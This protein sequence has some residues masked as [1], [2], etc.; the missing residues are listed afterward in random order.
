MGVPKFFRYVSERYPCLNE[1]VRENQIP[2][3]DNLYLDMNGIIH[4]CSH[5]DDGNVH[6]RMTEEQMFKA[7]FHYIDVLFRIIQPQ[8]LMF[9]AIDG[10][11]PRAKMNQQR[12]RRFRTAKE[13]EM[14]EAKAREKGEILPETAR[15]DSNC[16]TP[17][18][19][20]M[21]RLQ[22]ALKFYVK[23]RISQQGAWQK[24]KVILSGHETPGE[25]EHKIMEYIRFLKSKPDW[26][27]NTRHCL[28]GLDADLIMLGL[29]THEQHFSL[30]R[31][32]V[33]FGRQAK[34]TT[35]VDT[36]RF[37]L[38]HL[39][40]LRE[41]IEM[42]FQVL[43]TTLSFPFDIESIVDDWV[44]MGF[45]VGNDF[46]PHLPNLHIN[47]NA[48]PD[49]YETYKRV[50]PTLDGYINDSGRINLARLEVLL[51]KLGEKDKE[52]FEAHYDDLRYLESKGIRTAF[53]SDSEESDPAASFDGMSDDLARLAKATEEM[54]TSTSD[55]EEENEEVRFEKDF[56]K[57]KRNYY[58]TKLNYPKVDESVLREQTEC[59]IEALQWTLYYYYRGIVSWGWFYPHHY[60]PFVS[61]LKDFSRFNIKFDMGKPFLPFEQLLAV[62]PSASRAHLPSAYQ[63]LMTD[64]QSDIIEYY[65]TEFETDLNGK[66]QEWEAVVL[67]PFI[68]E[69]RLLKAMKACYKD[70]TEEEISRNRHGPML[71]YEYVP[72]N[73]GQCVGPDLETLYAC[74]ANETPI[75]RADIHVPPDRMVLKMSEKTLKGVLFPGFPTTKHLKYTTKLE[76]ARVKVFEAHSM[77]QTM[78][79]QLSPE[80]N[81][82]DLPLEDVARVLVGKEIFIGWPHLMEAKVVAVGNEMHRYE[83]G[84]K[85]L[86]TDSR[87]FR[88]SIQG[89]HDHH[90]QRLGIEIG[91]TSKLVYVLPI[92]SREYI[93][94]HSGVI[95]LSKKWS[96]VEQ[97]YPL[98][99]VVKDLTVHNSSFMQFKTVEEIFPVGGTIFLLST[100]QYG[101]VGEV[102]DT[103]TVAKNERIRVSLKVFPEP[104][105]P[106]LIQ[107]HRRSSEKYVSCL[108][109]ATEIGIT[110][111]ILG[112]ITGSVLV[113]GGPRRPVNTE[114][115]VR[116]VNVGLL[117]QSRKANVE[118]PGYT[119]K[120]QGYWYYSKDVVKIV[121]DYLTKFPRLFN[122][123]AEKR[124]GDIFEQD[125]QPDQV[126]GSILQE[127]MAF[128]KEQP[129]Y[130]MDRQQIGAQV[131][132]KEIIEEV[133]EIVE[134]NKKNLLY[135][136]LKLQ[137]KPHLVYRPGLMKMIKGPDPD[138]IFKL[139]DRV[140]VATSAYPV[141]MAMKGTIVSIIPSV[142]PNPIR[143][144]TRKTADTNL[145][146]V[147]FDDEFEAG[148]SLYGLADKRVYR[149]PDYA[150]INIT[151]GRLK[152]SNNGDQRQNQQQQSKQPSKSS[153]EFYPRNP[154]KSSE[155]PGNREFS[156]KEKFLENQSPHPVKVKMNG[157]MGKKDSVEKDFNDVWSKLKEQ[158][159]PPPLNLVPNPPIPNKP[160]VEAS[161]LSDGS[162]LLRKLLKMDMKS[163]EEKIPTPPAKL[164][165]PP[166]NWRQEAA[167]HKKCNNSAKSEARSDF[168]KWVITP[169]EKKPTY[170]EGKEGKKQIPPCPPSVPA[171]PKG[172]FQPNL[173]SAFAMHQ[174]RHPVIYPPPPFT[175][176]FPCWPVRSSFPQQPL[177]FWPHARPQGFPGNFVPRPPQ[178]I[179]PATTQSGNSNF[180]PLQ[181]ARKIVKQKN[182]QQQPKETFE[183]RNAQ[184]RQRV[185]K[186][187]QE[188]RQ[189]FTAFM[190]KISSDAPA[191]TQ[192]TVI[193]PEVVVKKEK[194]E[195]PKV[196]NPQVEKKKV[197]PPAPRRARI[198]AKFDMSS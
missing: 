176:S 17:G 83:E 35:S 133:I 170:S 50:L 118:I 171:A 131:V 96:R 114:D 27:P 41:Y 103:N 192:D 146:D 89:L 40:L 58:M 142:D 159:L 68:K 1:L 26:D 70:L 104:E 31:E 74:Y 165:P 85:P 95:T 51:R 91:T 99:A 72:E 23:Q 166:M 183:E 122:V 61:D 120:I 125:L 7:I 11:A 54:F 178:Q 62:L 42:E 101:C 79:I 157:V 97:A 13:A 186:N 3:F 76:S 43:K 110:P 73:Q 77:N 144:E 195:V 152:N 150:L 198:A 182:L 84:L 149:L 179:S 134:E 116:K 174:A 88:M 64:P 185:V 36:T 65:P 109:A 93:F 189:K 4:N 117:M 86:E 37:F 139:F 100:P 80:S 154:M 38:L 71:L 168:P 160:A 21:V 49:I 132:E 161:G 191:S 28:Y 63:G 172:N 162:D 158:K 14:L 33:R 30:L 56:V 105:F 126:D 163:D 111:S 32:E 124:I 87:S 90:K 24:C 15:F 81:D 138:A 6:Y 53:D 44:M 2:E 98:Q 9:M 66:R 181:A 145:I 194:P 140:I 78:M 121:S 190:S 173:Q 25:G 60:A 67:I 137:I 147:L 92:E 197:Q 107:K 94:G 22:E 135:K 19:P 175:G 115:N 177:N 184:Q 47:T 39:G 169:D 12:G 141:P 69:D 164:P 148:Q 180:I 5:P 130:N 156:R 8:K 10:V 123:L 193:P 187:Q 20:F 127:M 52:Y 46:I 143:F 196:E 108:K 75:D 16:I 129:H 48:L 151:Y 34:P 106:E 113:I 18:T 102:L 136:Q 188:N 155:S 112:M 59:Y 119:K 29:C 167:V 153:R 128:V 57:Y 45:L 55:S 82:L